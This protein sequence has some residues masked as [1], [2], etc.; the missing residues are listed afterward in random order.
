MFIEEKCFLGLYTNF[1]CRKTD[2]RNT[3]WC[4]AVSY[5]IGISNLICGKLSLIALQLRL[6]NIKFLS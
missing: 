2:N 5:L 1:T 3:K 4:K 6:L